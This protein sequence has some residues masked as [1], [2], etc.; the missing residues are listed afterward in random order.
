MSSEQKG[1]SL[2]EAEV[3]NVIKALMFLTGTQTPKINDHN[4]DHDDNKK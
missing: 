4:D 2:R 3:H 1:I